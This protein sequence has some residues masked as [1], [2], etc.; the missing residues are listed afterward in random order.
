[1]NLDQ[2]ITITMDTQSSWATRVYDPHFDESNDRIQLQIQLETF[3]LDYRLD[4]RFIYRYVRV[5]EYR[6]GIGRS[7]LLT[8]NLVINF[9]K[10][11]CCRNT[12]WTSTST[13]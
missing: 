10:M 6:L 9:A 4:N 11:R 1:M 7:G 5:T 12:I 3:V 13:T 8:F 2:Q